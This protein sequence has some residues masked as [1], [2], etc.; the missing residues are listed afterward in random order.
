MSTDTTDTLQEDSSGRSTSE[1]YAAHKKIYAKAVSGF[2]TNWRWAL[3]WITQIVFYGLPWMSWNGRSAVL[4]NLETRRFYLF[5][6]VLYPQDFIFLTALLMISAYA[7]FL[8][9]AVAGRLWCGYACPQTVYTEIFMW[10]EKKF[11]GDRNARMKLDAA[12][13]SGNKL[14]RKIGKQSAWMAISL[15]T[16]FT[17]V[18]YFTPMTRLLTEAGSLDFG[19]WEWFWIFFYGAA[20]YGFAGFMREQICK[21][22][23]PYARFQGAMFDP[24]TLIITY[25]ENRGEPRGSRGKKVDYKSAGMGS[26]VDCGLCV[27]VCPTGIDIRDGQQYECIGCAACIDVCDGVMDKMGYERGLVRYSTLNGMKNQ[28]TKA[29]Q[30]RHIFRPRVLIYTGILI[31]VLV[32]LFYGIWSRAPFKVD[33]LRD[34]TT[35]ARVVEDGAVENIYRLQIMNATEEKQVYRVKVNGLDNAR[36]IPDETVQIAPT[37]AE[38]ITVSVRIPFDTV[39]KE[40]SGVKPLQFDVVRQSDNPDSQVTVREKSTFVIPR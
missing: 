39:Q 4:F 32:A 18:A 20:T 29:D 27:Q 11:E 7:L 31:V 1:L 3:V 17:F 28:W 21:Y 14:M 24:D 15:W 2:F 26:C 9:T 16:G 6:M 37:E 30:I 12:P 33:V 25:D 22:L 35:L 40:S 23:C 13:W 34:R 5:D 10:V 36:I 8:F 19:P 38:W